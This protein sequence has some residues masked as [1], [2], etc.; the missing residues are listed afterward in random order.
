MDATDLT[1]LNAEVEAWLTRL[2]GLQGRAS[3]E[4]RPFL[5]AVVQKIRE[6]QTQFNAEYARMQ[7]EIQQTLDTAKQRAENT[8]REVEELRKR[9]AEL[10]KQAGAPPAPPSPPPRKIERGLGAVLRQEL[11]SRFLSTPDD[12]RLT[13]ESLG[14]VAKHWEESEPEPTPRPAPPPAEPPAQPRA[15]PAPPKSKE[16]S[17]I[18]EDLSDR[19]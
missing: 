2:T 16:G 3:G 18:W 9:A 4:V 14:S 6:G 8:L 10:E 17:E 15:K 13:E 5:D 11:L 1:K 7:A 19:D 12:D